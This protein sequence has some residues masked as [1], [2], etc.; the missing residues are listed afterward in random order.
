MAQHQNRSNRKY[1]VALSFAG[2]DRTYVEAVASSLKRAGVCVFYDRYEEAELWGK[3]L[4]DHLQHVYAEAAEYTVMFVSEAYDRKLWTT[5]ERR[6]A[7]SRAFEERREYILPA[8]FDDTDIPGL[9]KTIGYVD[10]R[11]KTPEELSLLILKKLRPIDN[12]SDSIDAKS[13]ED[14]PQSQVREYDSMLVHNIID[15]TVK[16]GIRDKLTPIEIER[17]IDARFHPSAL[18]DTTVK[19]LGDKLEVSTSIG[20]DESFVS[21]YSK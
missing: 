7:Q 1:D 21:W 11:Q 14:L 17:A 5:W 19:D 6:A 2:E 20:S 9:L 8:R 10:L 12:A 4:Y 15:I 16:K 3:N 13:L 18:I